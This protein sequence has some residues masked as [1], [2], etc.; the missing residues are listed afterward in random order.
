MDGDNMRLRSIALLTLQAICAPPRDTT[1]VG[2]PSFP[3]APK[4]S[5]PKK[6]EINAEISTTW[7]T[8]RTRK[9]S[10][11]YKGNRETPSS[12]PSVLP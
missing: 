3:A 4:I 1:P 6:R 5:A 11:V 12:S 7:Y 9:H 10:D 8:F 2:F